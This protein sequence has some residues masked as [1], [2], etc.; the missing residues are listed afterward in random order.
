MKR[1]NP[2]RRMM[3]N[4]KSLTPFGTDMPCRA[5]DKTNVELRHHAVSFDEAMLDGRLY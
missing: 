1:F 4:Q 3:M 5:R 2:E